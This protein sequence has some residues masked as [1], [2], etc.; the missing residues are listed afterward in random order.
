MSAPVRQVQVSSS[1]LGALQAA[2]EQTDKLFALIR[3]GFLYERPIPYRHR[4]IFYLGHLE[5][6]DWNQLGIWNLSERPF[7]ASFDKL[8]EAGIDPD[9]SG[10]PTDTPADW[11]GLD[12]VLGYCHRARKEVD[13]LLSD[14]SLEVVQMAL[15]HRLMHAE[16]LAYLLHNMPS[17]QKNGPPS[18]PPPQSIDNGTHLV[19]IPAGVATLGQEPCDF[20]WDNEFDRHQVTVPDFYI[21]KYNVT[22]GDYL[23]YVE[24]GAP[25]PHY[26]TRQDGKWLLRGMFGLMPLPLNWPVFVT[27]QEAAAFAKSRRKELPTEAQFHRA[28]YGT[29]NGV[30]MWYPWGNTAPA[31]A[32]GNFDFHHWNPIPVDASPA[33]D[34]VF[35]VSQ[36][37]GNGWEWTSTLFTPFVGFKA[38]PNYPG[39][40]ANFFDEEH[41]VMKGASP[42]TAARFLRRSFRNWFRPD[43]PYVYAT[44]RC[45]EN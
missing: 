8:F 17:N 30:E 16:T 28:A 33:G 40:S 15:E 27:L 3:P 12:E 5:A 43:Y 18:G 37:V 42:R 20:G 35:G 44:F 14:A 13:R 9:S 6:F 25:A 1:L 29:R 23:D 10:L 38:R 7:H 41:Y 19:K 24:A 4:M 21:D 34:S 39:Y 32:H 31:A 26:W 11:P 45:V 2:R 36:L 22:N